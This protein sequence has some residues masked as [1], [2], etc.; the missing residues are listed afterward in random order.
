M[1]DFIIITNELIESQL[2]TERGG[3]RNAS[4]RALGED[5]TH[6]WRRR[7]IGKKVARSAWERAVAGRVRVKTTKEQ[8]TIQNSGPV[9][10]PDVLFPY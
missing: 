9:L 10:I 8:R 5:V 2:L 3:I 4:I 6:G 7:L 1:E